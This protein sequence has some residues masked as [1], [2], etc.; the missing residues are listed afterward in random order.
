ML[1]L[2]LC[3]NIYIVGFFPSP[4]NSL[5]RWFC[6]HCIFLVVVLVSVSFTVFAIG[7]IR[8]CVVTRF[9]FALFWCQCWCSSKTMLNSKSIN[10]VRW[11]WHTVFSFFPFCCFVFLLVCLLLY[12]LTTYINFSHSNFVTHHRSRRTLS[13]C[14]YIFAC[15]NISFGFYPLSP[16][17]RIANILY[18]IRLGI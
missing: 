16:F 5:A 12:L 4:A 9:F 3:V 18:F 17:I 13:V 6:A 7:T 2:Y 8:R 11:R 15:F 10:R 14:V 1:L